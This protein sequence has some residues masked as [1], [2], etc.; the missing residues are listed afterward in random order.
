MYFPSDG[1]LASVRSALLRLQSTYRIDVTSISEGPIVPLKETITPPFSVDEC[2][3]MA[4]SAMNMSDFH[5]SVMWLEKS[6]SLLEQMTKQMNESDG[7]GVVS[8]EDI[9]RMMAAAQYNGR[10]Q[11]RAFKITKELLKTDPQNDLYKK[12]RDFYH[13]KAAVSK[14]RLVDELQYPKPVE[15]SQFEKKYEKA[16]RGSGKQSPRLT[17]YLRCFYTNHHPNIILAPVKTEE[18]YKNPLVLIFHDLL[19]ATTEV[20]IFKEISSQKLAFSIDEE[21]SV[22]ER[23]NES[24]KLFNEDFL[25][26]GVIIPWFSES[27]DVEQKFS[28]YGAFD[29]RSSGIGQRYGPHH[30]MVDTVQNDGNHLATLQVYLSTVEY[31]GGTVF[32]LLGINI[33][34]VEGSAVYFHNTYSSGRY[35]SKMN[36]YVE[37]PVLL[38]EQITMTK[39]YKTH[40][41]KLHRDSKPSKAHP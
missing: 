6:R 41:Q 7:N 28:S 3:Q 38:G 18:V 15:L 5:H 21:Q 12:D 8:M 10:N 13:K 36:D 25:K 22:D 35:T 27:I 33:P 32:P 17:K 31:G 1:D 16:C 40:A 20:A 39:W 4:M 37:C 9:L 2:Y 14:Q 23:F 26:E 29:V 24:T 11:N 19:S 30:S 34:A